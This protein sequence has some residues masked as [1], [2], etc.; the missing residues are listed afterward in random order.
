MA[1]KKKAKS[2]SSGSRPSNG[3]RPKSP[4][5]AKDA[6]NGAPASNS[7]RTYSIPDLRQER[8]NLSVRQHTEKDG[9]VRYEVTGNLDAPVPPIRDSQYLSKQQCIEIY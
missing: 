3:A 5:L 4:L 1:V 2:S 9:H 7:I 8:P 6:R